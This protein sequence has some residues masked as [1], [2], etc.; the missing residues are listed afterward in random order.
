MFLTDLKL[1]LSEIKELGS[2][3]QKLIAN[4]TSR[5]ENVTDPEQIDVTKKKVP[6]Q[7]FLEQIDNTGELMEHSASVD[8]IKRR[9]CIR[10]D[11]ASRS[12]DEVHYMKFSKARRASF[13][14][15][16]RHKF[17]D[18]ICL[19]GIALISIKIICTAYCTF[20][21]ILIVIFI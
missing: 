5:I 19:D 4:D 13:A 2:S 11:I 3:V 20:Y 14:N 16:N 6:F 10:A 8:D 15:K 21:H 9:R 18:W 17:S 12:M 7:S 1:F